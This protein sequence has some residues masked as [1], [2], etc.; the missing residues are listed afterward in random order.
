M[1]NFSLGERIS[2]EIDFLKVLNCIYRTLRL[3]VWPIVEARKGS[4][5]AKGMLSREGAHFRGGTG[6]WGMRDCR[7]LF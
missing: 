3:P 4:G 7:M 2:G 1:R 6:M 5:A